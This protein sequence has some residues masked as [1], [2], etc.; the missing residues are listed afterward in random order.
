MLLD[1]FR[2]HRFRPVLLYIKVVVFN[3]PRWYLLDKLYRY[4]RQIG[5][6]L[7]RAGPVVLT[8]EKTLSSGIRV[9]SSVPYEFLAP[10]WKWNYGH[11]HH[12]SLCVS[13]ADCWNP[14]RP[15]W[16]Q[17]S[18]HMYPSD[19]TREVRGFIRRLEKIEPRCESAAEMSGVVK[20]W[21]DTLIVLWIV[22][23]TSAATTLFCELCKRWRPYTGHLIDQSN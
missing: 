9:Q 6:I 14:S 18:P 4:V 21:S 8:A 17:R 20:A 3:F 2:N 12:W 16:V 1:N 5:K 13:P 22:A 11:A 19:L 10:S 15:V 7:C 23:I